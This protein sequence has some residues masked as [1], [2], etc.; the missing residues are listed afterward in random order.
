MHH[1]IGALIRIRIDEES[2]NHAEDGSGGADAEGQRKYGSERESRQFDQLPD[3]V[4][5]SPG[6]E[7]ASG[8]AFLRGNGEFGATRIE[9]LAWVQFRR[10]AA[11]E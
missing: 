11:Q 4:A 1:A 10:R 2:V 5:H 6:I 8:T 9:S 7:S 3:T